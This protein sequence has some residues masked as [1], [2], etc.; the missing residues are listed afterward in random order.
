MTA[1]RLVREL[2]NL[3][4][5]NLLDRKTYPELVELLKTALQL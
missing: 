1:T 4:A 2:T 5:L 3:P